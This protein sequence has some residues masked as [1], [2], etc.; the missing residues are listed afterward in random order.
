[1]CYVLASLDAPISKD[2]FVQALQS[3][4]LINF[5][6]I[7]D[8]LSVLTLSDLIEADLKD[9]V[10]YLSLTPRGREVARQMETDVLF[11]ARRA[12]VAAALDMLSK[13]KARGGTK[14]EIVKLSRG[15]H[16]RLSVMDGD[17]LMMQ[18]VLYTADALQA[19]SIADRF[20]EDPKSVYAG[21]IDAV[22][23]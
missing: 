3:T 1:V 18:T 15:Y 12:A 21:I 5:F 23:R 7:G 8:A 17:T 14:T 2:G 22:I 10:E 9:G 20:A 6:E 11:T 19:N 13:E 16:V 4:D